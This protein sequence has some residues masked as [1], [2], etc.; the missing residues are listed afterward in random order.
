MHSGKTVS[1]QLLQF[2]PRYEFNL[3]VRRYR[4]EHRVKKFSTYDQFLYLAYAQRSQRAP[5]D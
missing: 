1:K 5:G 2:L 3:C 4:G